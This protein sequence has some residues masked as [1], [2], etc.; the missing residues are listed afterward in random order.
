MPKLETITIKG[1]KSI[2]DLEDFALN[3]LNVIVGAN[4]A[5]KSNFISFFRLLR[6]FMQGGLDAYVIEQGGADDMLHNGVKHTPRMEF[7]VMFGERG[8]EFNLS[9]TMTATL[10]SSYEARYYSKATHDWWVLNNR[11]SSESAM[12][13][14]ATGDSYDARYSKP[15]YDAIMAWEVYHFHDTSNTAAMRRAEIVEDNARLRWNAS[16]I[17]PYLLN[18]K[19]NHPEV[20]RQIVDVV[21]F[22]LPVFDDFLLL[23]QPMGPKTIV[24]L[25]WTQKGSDFPM[26]TYHLSDGTIRFIC[27]ATALLQHK[28]PSTIVLDEPELGLHPAAIGILAELIKAAATR[29]QVI[30]ATQSPLLLDYFSAEDIIVAT[31]KGGAS[32]FSRLDAESLRGWLEEYT[33]GELWVKNVIEGGPQYV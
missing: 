19:N 21:R 20:Y 31:H 9:P 33:L 3:D 24:K 16:N 25:G 10:Y 22:V 6:S 8:Y 11:H 32:H 30:V 15:V 13:K 27:L 26:Q 1:Y 2:A 4:G 7:K 28:L 29:T 5:G 14:E 17:A 12:A 23:P 18:L